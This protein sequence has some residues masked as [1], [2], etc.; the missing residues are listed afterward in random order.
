MD[1]SPANWLDWQ[2]DSKSFE[3]LAA[4]NDRFTL[5]LTGEGEPERL[6]AQLVSHEFLRALGVRAI[7]GRDFTAEDDQPGTPRRVILSYGLWQ[8]RFSGSATVVVRTLQRNA[9]PMEVIGVMAPGFRFM[10]NDDDVWLAYALNR[11]RRW[12]EGGGRSLPFVVGRLKPAVAREAAQ[13]EM[14][15]MMGL[16]AE[17]YPFNK[18]TSALLIPLREVLTGEVRSPLLVLLAA[19]G[20]LLRIA[21]C[22]VTNL[23]V[24][25][26][27]IAGAKSP[28]GRLWERDAERS[29]ARL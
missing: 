4:W 19:V 16:Y 22:N 18:D 3:A 10:S 1:V 17:L 28:S 20:V 9:T 29:S 12:W 21:C 23:L 8:R 27:V 5:S 25:R 26:G 13:S 2:R 15:A 14:N 6:K 24:A 11:N 7:L